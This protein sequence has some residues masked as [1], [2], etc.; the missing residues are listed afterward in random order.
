MIHNKVGP[1]K[2]R[3]VPRP[4]TPVAPVVN[5][6]PARQRPDNNDHHRRVTSFD[7]VP[8]TYAE[9]Y[10][11]LIQKNWVQTRSPLVVPKKLPYGYKQEALCAFHQNAPGHSLEDCFSLKNEVQKLMR[12][13][14]LTFKDTGPNVKTNP[15]PDHTGASTSMMDTD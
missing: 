13:G 12:A 14:I 5:V 7:P 6:A 15:M 1:R 9:L 8:M 11:I 3:N 4:A 2:G 10:P